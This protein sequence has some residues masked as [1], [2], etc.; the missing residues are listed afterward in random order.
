[1]SDNRFRLI[2]LQEAMN[3]FGIS[4]A[5]IDRWRQ[6]KQLPF[7]KIGKEVFINSDDLHQWI[8]SYTYEQGRPADRHNQGPLKISIGYQSGTAHMWSS[9]LIKETGF[10]EEELKTFFPRRR[11]EI[12]W[13]NG[14]NGLELLEGLIMGRIH[15]ASLGDYPIRM[16][17]TLSELLPSFQAVFLAFDGKTPNGKGISIVVPPNSSIRNLEDLTCTPI[18]TVPHSSASSRLEQLFASIRGSGEPRIIASPMGESMTGI[19]KSKVG[20][21]VMWEPYPSLLQDSGAGRIL[22]E[23]GIGEDYLTGII[24]HAQWAGNNASIVIAYLKAHLRAHHMIRTQFDKVVKLIHLSTGY[25]GHIARKV[26]QR[27]RW[28]AAIYERDLQTLDRLHRQR[29]GAAPGSVT[30]P[31]QTH[32]LQSALEHL[33]L[34]S[35]PDEPIPGEWAVEQRY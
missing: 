3:V 33:R 21:S 29:N 18:S 27:V 8:R 13:Y 12:D 10:F 34:P 7:I 9:L 26:L 11:F 31:V 19:S 35:I 6:T 16:A 1:M 22:F 28:D 5:T 14:S 32:F 20:A 15:I 23:E 17:Q 30:I 24:S 2:T 25:P 4:R